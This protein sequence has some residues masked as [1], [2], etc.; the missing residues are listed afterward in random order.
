MYDVVLIES[1]EVCAIIGLHPHER[2]H[3]QRIVVDLELSI[4]VVTHDDALM[5]SVDYA[6][7]SSDISALL[8]REKF[9]TLEFAAQSIIGNIFDR[10][11]VVQAVRCRLR[12]PIAVYAARYVGVMMFRERI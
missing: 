3:P 7:V 4:P 12:K 1:L 10:W 5:Q 6:V 8:E 11:N 9:Q 2:L